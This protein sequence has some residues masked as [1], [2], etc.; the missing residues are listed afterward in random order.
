M[1]A[2]GLIRYLIQARALV[3]LKWQNMVIEVNT[4]RAISAQIIGHDPSSMQGAL[5]RYSDVGL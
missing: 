4:L 1:K 2:I 5:Q 3:Y